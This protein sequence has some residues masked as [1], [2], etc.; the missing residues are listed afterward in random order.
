MFRKA[1]QYS[2]KFI[3]LDVCAKTAVGVVVKQTAGGLRFNSRA[4]QM[5]RSVS[6]TACHCCDVSSDLCCSGAKPQR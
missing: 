1:R 5:G 2:S 4:G 3:F 6:P